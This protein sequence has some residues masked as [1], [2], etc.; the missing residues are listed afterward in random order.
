VAQALVEPAGEAVADGLN[1]LDQDFTVVAALALGALPA[2]AQA[3]QRVR[4]AAT[5]GPH[6][7]IKEEEGAQPW[8]RRLL[9]RRAR[10][11]PMV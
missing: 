11:S 5:P 7:Q 10:R 6:A 8:R 1:R 2:L 3:P 9:S 4:I